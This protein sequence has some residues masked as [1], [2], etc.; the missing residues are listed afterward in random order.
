MGRAQEV[1]S[2]LP[3][4]DSLDYDL[5][6]AAILRVYELEP[7][8][9]RQKFRNHT[10]ASKQT[11]VKF[12]H[13]K[14]AMLEK[15]CIASEATTFECLQELILFKDFKSCLPENLVLHLNEQKVTTL[16]EAAVFADE[17]VL[18]HQTVFYTARQSQKVKGY[19]ERNSAVVRSSKTDTHASMSGVNVFKC[20]ESKH[21]CF[22]CLDPSH[23]IADCKAW[24]QKNAASKA[25]SV[26]HVAFEPLTEI[27]ETFSP[28]TEMFKLFLM[29][30]SVSISPDDRPKTVSVL[31]DT[32][33][34]HSFIRED[35]LPLSA[36]TYTGPNILVHGIEL[37]CIK[38]PVHSVFLKS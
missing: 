7:E 12:A 13:D 30:G 32:G 11:F 19:A 6:K 9:Y 15:W 35:A 21:V 14:K 31:R 18:T 8:A 33:A 3:N 38:V 17:Y 2:A 5:V 34:A 16:S 10:K 25:K 1:C 36:E 22:Y 26:A 20:T 4:E 29:S 23:L 27:A 28:G 24:K 37:G